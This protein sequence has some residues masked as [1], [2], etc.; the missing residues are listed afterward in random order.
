MEEEMA[1]CTAQAGE[2]C[3][4]RIL[5]EGV[6]SLSR[7]G[8]VKGSDAF[9]SLRLRPAPRPSFHISLESGIMDLS[10]RTKDLTESELLEL[11]YSYRKKKKWHRLSSGD[12]VD[13]RDPEALRE[14]D[15]LAQELDASMENLIRGKVQM[16]EYRALYLDRLLREHEEIASMRDRHF[17]G[18]IRSFRTIQDADFDVPEELEETLRPY[19]RALAGSWQMKWALAKPCRC[20]L[21]SRDNTGKVCVHRDFHFFQG[22]VSSIIIAKSFH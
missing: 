16:P 20:S 3:L 9:N 18:L 2:D 21:S 13:L 15:G 17:K 22:S 4:V 10:I 11:L 8:V 1:A 7:F 14:L 6:D 12:F 5:T 19:R